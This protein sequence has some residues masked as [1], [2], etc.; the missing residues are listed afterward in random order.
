MD[1][2]RITE[3]TMASNPQPQK[4]DLYMARVSPVPRSLLKCCSKSYAWFWSITLLSF[5]YTGEADIVALHIQAL[6][7]AGVKAKDIAVIAPYN[8]QVRIALHLTAS[9]QNSVQNS[10]SF[11]FRLR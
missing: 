9:K 2:E 5:S 6:I 7:E 11:T 4:G 8:L 1:R 10:S 3:N